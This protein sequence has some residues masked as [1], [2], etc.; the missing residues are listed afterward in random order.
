MHHLF[1]WFWLIGLGGVTHW[2]QQFIQRKDYQSPVKLRLSSSFCSLWSYLSLL[3][4]FLLCSFRSNFIGHEIPNYSNSS[5]KFLLQP[6]HVSLKTACF[7]RDARSLFIH[8]TKN[9]NFEDNSNQKS[10]RGES[11]SNASFVLLVL[12][13]CDWIGR[14]GSLASGEASFTE[15][16]QMMASW[17]ICTWACSS[18]MIGRLWLVSDIGGLGISFYLARPLLII[19][20]ISFRFQLSFSLLLPFL[21]L[22]F[23]S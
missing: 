18:R 4:E 5:S 9:Q 12:V 8:L 17:L 22:C 23:Q 20:I 6:F 19:I 16:S 15:A 21:C 14:G 11:D 1:C 10:S 2:N 7:H 3:K 13:D